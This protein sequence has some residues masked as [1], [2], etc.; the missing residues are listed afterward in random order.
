MRSAQ[1]LAAAAVLLAVGVPGSAAARTATPYRV[2][3]ITGQSDRP[4][5][6]WRQT[7]AA[8]RSVLD[9]ASIFETN[10]I[11]EP[12]AVNAAALAGY[13]ALILN[14]NGPR[15]GAAAESAIEQFVASGGGLVGF[16]LDSYGSFFG[17]RLRDGRWVAGDAGWLAFP[18]LIGAS[19]KPQNI[20]H[21]RRGVFPVRWTNPANAI[22]AGL[23]AEFMA[24]DELYHRMDPDASAQVLADAWSDPARGGTGRREPVVWTV[25]P[26]KGRV[27]YTTLGHDIAAW[28][29]PGL[30]NAFLRGTEWA[31]SGKVTLA[32]FDMHHPAASNPVK[33]LVLTGGHPY[34]PSFYS[35]LND[36]DGIAW[37]HATS[38]DE[39]PAGMENTWDVVLLHDMHETIGAVPQERLRA[40]VEAGRGVVSLHHAIVDF[41]SWPWWYEQVIGGKFFVEPHG[42]HPQSAYQEGVEFL[43]EPVKGKE[44]HPVLKGVEALWVYDEMY[45]GMWHSPAIDVLMETHAP[46]NDLPVVYIG[47]HP[48]ARVIYIQLGHSDHTM[49]HPGF[50]HL[51]RNAILWAGRRA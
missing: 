1:A 20:G 24:D 47:P 11:E 9:R 21:A 8:I 31:A 50:Q 25:R 26:G 5:H 51:L 27:F 33:V 32:P 19:W 13:D 3:I 29:Q 36:M 30:I 48:K 23:P 34:P 6:N 7:T 41:T 22:A 18:R 16:H 4:Y 39:L 38:L 28:Y 49:R 44:N 42:G 40:F 14:Y 35:L 10:V 12:R 37:Q 46:G 2:L 15:L 43:V 17:M 45:R